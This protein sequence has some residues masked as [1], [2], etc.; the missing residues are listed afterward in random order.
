M[1]RKSKNKASGPQQVA[2]SATVPWYK[3]VWVVV[4][5]TSVVV[6]AILLKGP[7]LLQNARIL[8]SE[9]RQTTS[10]FQSWAKEDASWTGN[11]TSFPEGIVDM[12]DMHLS[13]VDMQ[14]TIW[15][16]QGDIDGTIATKSICK[17]IPV[18]NYVLLRGKVSGDTAH[19]VAWDIVQGHKTD[20]AELTLVRDGGV[21]TVRPTS[22]RKE[23]FP[24]A[25]RLGRHPDESGVEP[26]PDQTFCNEERKAFKSASRA[27][28]TQALGPWGE[29]VHKSGLSFRLHARTKETVTF[30]RY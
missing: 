11:W 14:I 5:A 6:S 8:P 3:R 20:F 19:V 13:N 26:E 27:G 15:A 29:F 21:I 7:N 9:V 30:K 1:A 4:S 23:W 16:S 18:L 10:Q 22:G 17:S 12:A 25:A 28:S 24:L 2:P